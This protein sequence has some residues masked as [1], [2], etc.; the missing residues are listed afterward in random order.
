MLL[1]NQIV[2]R[3]SLDFNHKDWKAE[4]RQNFWTQLVQKLS[5]GAALKNANFC[6][7]FIWVI[8]KKK[9]KKN[10]NFLD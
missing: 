10:A 5:G 1:L 3:P 2:I 4:I 8:K 6:D 7:K 9:E